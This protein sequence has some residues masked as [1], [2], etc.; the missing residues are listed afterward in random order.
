MGLWRPA[1]KIRFWTPKFRNRPYVQPPGFLKLISVLSIFSIVGTVIFHL[2]V[3]L[4]D[5]AASTS[6]DPS[7]ALY[8]SVLHFLLPFAIALSISTNSPISR[9]LILLYF[10][11]LSGAT[12]LGKG[13]LGS[14]VMNDTQRTT[15]AIG[16]LLG[17]CAYLF[18]SPKMRAYYALLRGD[19]VPMG[20]GDEAVELVENP[21][22][23]KRGK[24]VLEWLVDHLEIIVVLGLIV[25]VILAWHSMNPS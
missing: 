21:W 12:V 8:I 23:G 6:I 14:I 18:L 17:V 9:L 15:S 11:V 19:A 20:T 1:T 24:A 25:S 2:V 13:Y 4:G 22:P 10:L 5:V 16:M 3:T 7:S